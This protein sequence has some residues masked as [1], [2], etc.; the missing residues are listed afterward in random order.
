LGNLRALVTGCAGQ[1]G[2]ILSA[3][4]TR[5]GVPV[6][7][8][9]KPGTDISVLRAYAPEVESIECDLADSDALIEVI[10]EEKPSHLWNFG[11][12]TNVGDSWKNADEVFSVNVESVKALLAGIRENGLDTRFFQ[13]SSAA[14]FEGTDSFPQTEN[15]TPQPKS[16]YA[17]SK[18]LAMELVRDARLRDG[19]FA[20][21][22]I[23]YNHESPLRGPDFVTRKITIAVARIVL[24]LQEKL[25]LGDIEVARD[26][27]WAPD[28]VRATMLMLS[29]SKPRDYVLATG[30]SHRLSFFVQRA[31]LASG[32]SNWQD[33]VAITDDNSRPQDTSLLVGDSRSAM[34][35]LGWSHSVDFDSM[36]ESMVHNDLAI[37]AN[38]DHV[39]E[40]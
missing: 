4:L 9:V 38:P 5:K 27:G 16:P 22:G 31:F 29:S 32:I 2:I 37:L 40:F 7:G 34:L 8:L 18:L 6:T 30:V 20:C 19:L 3:L 17:L 33:Y 36:V 15:T 12:F 35:E 28:Y 21:S 11:G 1:D 23:L 24:G 14:I 26:W 39:W 25:E 13:A 10:A